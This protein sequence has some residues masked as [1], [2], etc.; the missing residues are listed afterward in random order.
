MHGL[1]YAVEV[2]PL[3]QSDIRSLD[4]V[5]FRLYEIVPNKYQTYY[6]RLLLLFNFK[7]PSEH[8]HNRKTDLTRH[9]VTFQVIVK[10]L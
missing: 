8:I 3:S 6:K 4:F 1:L 10:C 5:I 9:S 2:C 7:L